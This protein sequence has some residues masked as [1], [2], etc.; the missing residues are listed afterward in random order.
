MRASRAASRQ[1]QAMDA[2]AACVEVLAKQMSR[3][4]KKLDAVLKLKAGEEPA[5]SASKAKVKVK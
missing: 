2:L 3:I 1:A 4:E 5:A